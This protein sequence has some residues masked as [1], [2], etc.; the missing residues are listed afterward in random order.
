MAEKAEPGGTSSSQVPAGNGY[1]KC[2]ERHPCK[3]VEVGTRPGPRGLE[4]TTETT[5]AFRI[6]DLAVTVESAQLCW[7]YAVVEW[8]KP[9]FLL[10][11]Y[12]IRKARNGH[13]GS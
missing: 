8:G 2:G 13:L 11:P 10:Q 1:L 3:V 6:D 12:D 4:I 9:L 5:N 7:I